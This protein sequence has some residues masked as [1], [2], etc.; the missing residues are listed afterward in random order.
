MVAIWL[1]CQINSVS[2]AADEDQGVVGAVYNVCLQI[3]A[4][5]GIAI[6]NIIANNKNGLYAVGAQLLPGYLD[7]FYSYS[8]MAGVGLVVTLILY[9]NSDQV[10]SPTGA[11]RL[12]VEAVV[13]TD[14]DDERVAKGNR[15]EVVGD[16][17]E[18][19]SKVTVVNGS[20]SSLEKRV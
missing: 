7:A 18:I 17:S 12:D 15:D 2:D 9:P 3:G 10:R 19:N 5:L 16:E 20:S 8:V 14:G 6:S 13:T 1:T 4:P 11:E